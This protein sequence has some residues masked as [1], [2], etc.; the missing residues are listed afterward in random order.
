MLLDLS[1]M[2]NAAR[3]RIRLAIKD[4]ALTDVVIRCSSRDDIPAHKL[5]HFWQRLNEQQKETLAKGSVY[6]HELLTAEE[7]Y[8]LLRHL[9][10]SLGPEGIENS[11]Y[12]RREL[13]VVEEYEGEV[14]DESVLPAG[15]FLDEDHRGIIPIPEGGGKIRLELLAP[16]SAGQAPWPLQVR[17]YSQGFAAGRSSQEILWE[18][19]SPRFEQF[20]AEGV[21]EVRGQHEAVIRAV[22]LQN[23]TA[24]DIT[25]SPSY[26]RAYRV[27]GK[28]P[29]EFDVTHIGNDPTPFRV[30]LRCVLSLQDEAVPNNQCAVY[31]ELLDAQNQVVQA[32]TL[33]AASQLSLYDGL[34]D[35]RSTMRVSDPTVYYF[36]LHPH[37]RCIRFT[38]ATPV[39]VTAYTRPPDLVREIRVPEDAHLTGHNEEQQPAWFPLRPKDYESVH[40]ANRSVSLIVQHRPPEDEP[41]V[42][43]GPYQWEDYHPE[44]PWLARYVFVPWESGAPIREE[45]FDVL[46]Y[47]I[48]VGHEVTLHVRAL[49][50]ESHARPK[51]IF[52]RKASIPSPVRLLVDGRVVY[53]K[54]ITGAAGELE[55]PALPV[56]PHR[57][58]VVLSGPVQ[59][60]VN[61]V[62]R[63]VPATEAFLKRLVNR[64]DHTELTFVYHKATAGDETL[65]ARLYVPHGV[66]QRSHMRVRISTPPGVS[67]G[68]TSQRTFFDRRY[69][70]RP[71]QGTVLPV[72]HTPSENVDQGPPFFIPLRSDLP[73]GQYR[74]R[75]RLE[76]GP[77]GYLV[78]AKITPGVFEKRT[79]VQEVTSRAVEVVEDER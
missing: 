58:R 19:N 51:L 43:A 67:P 56:G 29:L 78:L 47:R 36:A 55:L 13:Y 71:S 32:N 22:L 66:T 20:F 12:Q 79:L 37:I 38:A 48:P 11:D 40:R 7:K 30:D 31:Y 50:G 60:F 2:E 18:G 53:Q 34:A 14:V 61:H 75:I 69:D 41:S 3:V 63:T 65:S 16:N 4:P 49:T 9:W 52:V 5:A 27:Q 73:P 24:Q 17:W 25:P 74:I 72:L 68:P 76:Q 62:E 39:L 42:L 8:N 6:E 77:G 45:L 57:L 33:T 54:P 26:M 70:I 15:L 21:L 10:K 35:G 64:F 46:Y 1:G 28:T 23:G 44:G 59:V